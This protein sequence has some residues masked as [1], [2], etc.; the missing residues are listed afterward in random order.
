MGPTYNG[1]LYVYTEDGKVQ[2]IDGIK[3]IHVEA[4]EPEPRK[5]GIT[6]TRSPSEPDYVI[7]EDHSTGKIKCVRYLR[8]NRYPSDFYEAA[9]YALRKYFENDF[10]MKVICIKGDEH[11]HYR[12]IPGKVYEIKNGHLIGPDGFRH[13]PYTS[14]NDLNNSSGLGRHCQFIEF[15]GEA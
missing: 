6:I 14:L 12:Y 8:D 9:L 13:G 3:A 11:M 7:V 1:K 2:E 10:N 15:K 4:R 5:E